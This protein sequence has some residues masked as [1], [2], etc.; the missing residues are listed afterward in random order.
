ME[1]ERWKRVKEAVNACLDLKPED[2]AAGIR[3]AC[4]GETALMTEVETLLNS[5]DRAGDFLENPIVDAGSLAEPEPENLTGR[6][7]GNYQISELIARGG[8]GAVYK[9][10]RADD[11]FRKQVAIKL[12]LGGF[13]SKFIV[14]RFKA[15]RQILAGFD[16][17]NIARLLDGGTTPE[18]LPYL[19]MEYV[20]GE[21]I[22]VYCDS[23]KLVT[24]DRLQLFRQVCG[25]VQ[26]AHQN[27]VIHRDLKPSN[28]LVT[29]EG[30][31][32]LL[33]FGIAKILDPAGS[34]AASSTATLTMVQMLTPE[35][36]SPEQFRG[37]P[38]TT[39]T[40]VYSMGVVLYR[41]LTGCWPYRTATH[42]QQEIAQ[43]ICEQEPEKP[44]TALERGTKAI[45]RN[46]RLDGDLDNILLKALRKEPERRYAS[47]EQFSEDIRRYLEG[48]PVIAR[49]DTVRYRA[50]KFIKRH[51]AGVC[52][53]AAILILLLAGVI[54]SSWLAIRA[55]RAEQEARAV[56]DFLQNDLLAQASAN[57]QSASR[58]KPDRDLKVRTALDRAAARIEGKFDRQPEVEAS[59]R[60]T[61]G[62]TYL[63]LGI[64]P[65][66]RTQL[67]HARDQYRRV[68]GATDPKTLSIASR[69]GYVL[70]VQGKYPEAE[71]LLSET[72]RT[73]LQTLGP[74]NKD[75]LYSSNALANLYASEGKYALAESLHSRTLEIRRRTLGPENAETLTLI[76][77]LAIDYEGQGRYD[78]AIDLFSQAVE[79]RRR[80]LGPEH[81]NTLGSM[82]NLANAYDDEGKYSLSR[83]LY[84][85]A[86]EIRRRI[87][88]PEHPDTVSSM[89]NLATS[90][91]FGGEFE[92]AE[93]LASEA[94][95][96]SRR[97]FGP[98]HFF[99]LNIMNNLGAVYGAQGKYRQAEPLLTQTVET[100][101][102]VLGAEHPLTLSFTAETAFLYQREGKFL[103]AEQYARAAL[104]GRRHALGTQ[105]PETMPS[106]S[107]LALALYSQGRFGESEILAREAFEFERKTQPDDWQGFRAESLLGAILAGEKKYPDAE[108]LLLDG[109]RGLVM[110]KDRIDVP[111]WYYLDRSG[112]WVSHLYNDWGKPKQAAEWRAKLAADLVASE[113]H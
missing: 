30:M 77:N 103:E 51:Q 68:A 21:P 79:G 83:P 42:S 44:S 16:Q 26:F 98:E 7:I 45:D 39:A 28:I 6:R 66:A 56:N 8:M 94:L 55:S 84:S 73:Q 34:D 107:D 1:P 54:V 19:V 110:R 90:Y 95:G 70:Y 72:H 2:R 99:T 63:D 33:D 60:E 13:D 53:A 76:N 100:S 61:I 48:L 82:N 86:L 3:K 106:A 109:Y 105:H 10:V 81:P 97:L 57:N 52:A 50:G 37:G 91:H 24:N 74:E 89:L 11:Q 41:L 36:A 112:E 113:K 96:I 101:R 49:K 25:A 35:Y 47:V 15:E 69:I 4:G 65:E 40:D 20:D 46:L 67:E 9:A 22:D 102:R 14:P 5:F 38:F 87:L 71:R 85:Q 23:R 29:A 43:A 62:R 108:P 93:T 64:Y 78:Q 75:T 27:L 104:T 12:I 32:K 92:Q 31:P 58:G 111:D 80:V 18:G 88:G 17:P 59:I